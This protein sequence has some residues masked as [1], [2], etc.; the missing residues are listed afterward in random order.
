MSGMCKSGHASVCYRGAPGFERA[1]R[2]LEPL[3]MVWCIQRDFLQGKSTQAALQD[4]LAPVPNPK[5][6]AS[7][8]QV[9]CLI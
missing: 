3:H 2:Y 8:D 9:S 7:I 5:H 6:E 4:S 1:S